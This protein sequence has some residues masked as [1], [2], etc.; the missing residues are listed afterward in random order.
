MSINLVG[1]IPSPWL[2]V[3][4]DIL[5][6][7]R[8]GHIT[9]EHA[10]RFAKMDPTPFAVTAKNAKR[11]I[12][13]IAAK[14]ARKLSAIF[15]K[16]IL[17][18]PIPPEFTEENLARWA[19]SNYHPV[20]LPGENITEERPLKGWTKLSAWFYQH[21]KNGDI[22]PIWQG[23]SPTMLQRGWYL[24]DFTESADYM[25]G[26]QVFPNDPLSP[27]I[28]KLR[29]QKLV[30]KFDNMPMGSRFAITFTEWQDV[31]LAHIAGML[32]IARCQI[33]L[34]R[35][36]EFNAIGNLYDSHRGKFNVWEWFQDPFGDSYRLFGGDR[37]YGGLANINYYWY[38]YRNR[39]LAGRPLV[40]FVR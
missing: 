40:S 10:M 2:G 17:V 7:M 31:V 27:T 34:E 6:K 11:E 35:A 9:L 19:T 23:L 39:S 15:K 8:S 28:A 26:M 13:K 3:L 12:E 32:G 5:Q 14:T 4:V 22:K 16:R 20:F 29:E 25:D 38:D 1:D 18:D 36:I 30:G 33:H 21:A 37:D 24:A